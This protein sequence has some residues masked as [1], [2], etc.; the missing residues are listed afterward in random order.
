MDKMVSAHN[1]EGPGDRNCVCCNPPAG[2]KRRAKRR[3]VK[4][5]DRAKFRRSVREYFDV[6][7]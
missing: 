2:K 1:P 4:R 7:R 6:S 5:M 3:W